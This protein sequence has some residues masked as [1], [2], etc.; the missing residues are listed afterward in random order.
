MFLSFGVKSRS[1]NFR[2]ATLALLQKIVISVALCAKC[3]KMKFGAQGHKKKIIIQ[4]FRGTHW[5]YRASFG[6][7]RFF[8]CFLRSFLERFLTKKII[9]CYFLLYLLIYHIFH[10]KEVQRQFKLL[11]DPFEHQI[12]SIINRQKPLNQY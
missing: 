4:K 10:K 6:G 5:R 9:F 3:W 2:L 12:N 1:F 11:P 8:L 7:R